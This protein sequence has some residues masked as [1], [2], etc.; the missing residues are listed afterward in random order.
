MKDTILWN[1]VW[2]WKRQCKG[3][4]LLYFDVMGVRHPHYIEERP[5]CMEKGL[6]VWGGL[7][8]DHPLLMATVHFGGLK[9]PTLM[10]KR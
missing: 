9:E 4:G 5:C 2:I 10:G 7:A 1:G 6:W 3:E 8:D